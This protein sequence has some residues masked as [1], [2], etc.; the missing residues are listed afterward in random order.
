MNILCVAI[1]T[2][3]VI[4]MIRSRHNEPLTLFVTELR[5]FEREVSDAIRELERDDMSVVVITDN[6][7]GALFQHHNIDAVYATCTARTDGHYPCAPGALLA[8]VIAAEFTTPLYLVT[9]DMPEGRTNSSF[10]GARI[11]V[12]GA[13]CI[14]FQCDRV[15]E[16][17]V[18]EVIA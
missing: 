17:L 4:A 7:I 6:M 18:T 10:F 3:P 2:T 11:A 14:D 12:E 13:H 15:P 9:S 1:P 8:A 5:P 16:T